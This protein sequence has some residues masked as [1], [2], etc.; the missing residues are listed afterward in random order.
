MVDVKSELEFV[1]I[2]SFGK[3]DVIFIKLFKNGSIIVE[4]SIYNSDDVYIL[5]ENFLMF[6]MLFLFNS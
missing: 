4:D 6:I 3:V 2:D 5:Y 1:F